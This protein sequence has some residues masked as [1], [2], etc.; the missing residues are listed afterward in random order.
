MIFGFNTDVKHEDTIYHVQ[1]EAREADLLLQTQVFVRGRCIGKRATSYAEQA[2]K[3]DFTDQKKEQILR[4]QHRLVL[5]AIREGRL[6]EVFDNRE[7]PETLAAIKQLDI[8]WLNANSIHAEEKLS[9]RL[10]ATEDGQGIANARLIVRLARA[11]AAPFYTQLMTDH[12]G[13]AELVV[14]VDEASLADSSVLVQV[15][16]SGRTATRK[17]Q[18]R[19]V[20]A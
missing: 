3:P 8:Q 6:Q 12:A 11:N 7:T 10:R 5:E 20:E 13:D 1:S 4:E 14:L 15:N 18:L 17:F 2:H 9:V 19:R 16:S